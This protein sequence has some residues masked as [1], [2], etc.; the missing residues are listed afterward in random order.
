M[1]NLELERLIKQHM[2]EAQKIHEENETEY[3]EFQRRLQE[4]QDLIKKK[5][6]KYGGYS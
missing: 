6:E 3:Q 2:K 4:Q 5:M 1:D